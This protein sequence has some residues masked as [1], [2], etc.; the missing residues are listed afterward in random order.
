VAKFYASSVQAKNTARDVENVKQ[1]IRG[2]FAELDSQISGSALTL[3][4]S[5]ENYEIFEMYKS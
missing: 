5:L 3:L 4:F 2:E 1:V